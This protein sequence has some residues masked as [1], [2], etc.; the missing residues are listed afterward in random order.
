MQSDLGL[1]LDSGYVIS[2]GNKTAET[3]LNEIKTSKN[4]TAIL[5]LEKLI[6][7]KNGNEH[8]FASIIRIIDGL[9]E[10]V[11]KLEKSLCVSLDLWDRFEASL[12]K[13]QTEWA[14]RL[15]IRH[16]GYKLRSL[17]S[18]L[19]LMQCERVEGVEIIWTRAVDINNVTTCFEKMIGR[20]HGKL[21][22]VDLVNHELLALPPEINCD[23]LHIP[24]FVEDIYGYTWMMRFRKVYEN[25]YIPLPE[26]GPRLQTP[27]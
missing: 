12:A 18:A 26:P 15:L 21:Y 8:S 1:Y 5:D 25:V 3:T 22:E 2:R 13:Y 24:L 7:E 10:H 27:M 14:S 16:P 23:E 6:I 4:Y 9:S 20:Y 17:G 11:G 19:G